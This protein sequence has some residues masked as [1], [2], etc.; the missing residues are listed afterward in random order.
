MITPNIEF[1]SL[2]DISRAI[3]ERRI[4]ER[5][6]PA[7]VRDALGSMRTLI[8]QVYVEMGLPTRFGGAP[9]DDTAG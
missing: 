6:M 8:D 4:G 3:A 7:G 2:T 1:A 9:A 5:A